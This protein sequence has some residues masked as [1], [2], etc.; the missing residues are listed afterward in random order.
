VDYRSDCLALQS[1][2][3]CQAPA[4]DQTRLQCARTCGL[5]TTAPALPP[6]AP[7]AS[8]TTC[9]ARTV[10]FANLGNVRI[11]A[12]QQACRHVTPLPRG[13]EGKWVWLS[14]VLRWISRGGAQRA[15][16][17]LRSW[18]ILPECTTACVIKATFPA[19]QPG[20]IV[21][22]DGPTADDRFIVL[23]STAL[24]VALLHGM[25]LVH[26]MVVLQTLVRNS[27]FSEVR[28]TGGSML[29]TFS[30]SGGDQISP[31]RPLVFSYLRQVT[32]PS[33]SR[34]RP[35]HRACVCAGGRALT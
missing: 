9:T 25:T 27:S 26:N 28:S 24:Q 11:I 17:Y 23:V 21:V 19:A 20:T 31:S 15:I 5:C 32:P 30:P 34:P 14:R 4:T 16:P 33:P 35:L 12:A 29:I 8:D 18:L 7:P 1:S 6:P 3:V 13:A 2:G 10:L 22:Y